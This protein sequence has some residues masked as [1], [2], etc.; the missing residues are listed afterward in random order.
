MVFLHVWRQAKKTKY[1]VANPVSNMSSH[2]LKHLV[3][4]DLL[5]TT[6]QGLSRQTSEIFSPISVPQWRF[7]RSFFTAG[8][9][10]T[11]EMQ[12]NRTEDLPVEACL[13]LT[14]FWISLFCVWNV[15]LCSI[16]RNASVGDTTINKIII[17]K[18]YFSFNLLK[19]KRYLTEIEWLMKGF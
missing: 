14:L 7:N 10:S 19:L 17:I 3:G 4:L 18:N 9:I 11:N 6:L 12:K 15:L 5:E 16:L 8:I 13:L 1:H 2:S